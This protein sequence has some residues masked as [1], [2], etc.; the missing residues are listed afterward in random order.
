MTNNT[1]FIPSWYILGNLHYNIIK[2]YN[3]TI[4]TKICKFTV[5]VLNGEEKAVNN[6]RGHPISIRKFMLLE[7][8]MHFIV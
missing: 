7:C 8:I 2:P 3:S 1:K 4:F 5:L 6:K